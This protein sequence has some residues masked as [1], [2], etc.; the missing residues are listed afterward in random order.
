MAAGTQTSPRPRTYQGRETS[1]RRNKNTGIQF[2]S[3]SPSKSNSNQGSPGLNQS[4]SN[5][6]DNH[7]VVGAIY[8]STVLYLGFKNDTAMRYLSVLSKPESVRSPVLA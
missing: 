6:N 4:T 1:S 3:F 8:H 5:F 2:S 7:R